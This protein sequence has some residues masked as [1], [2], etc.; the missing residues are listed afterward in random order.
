VL[1]ALVGATVYE[2]LVAL[3]AIELGYVPGDGPPGEGLV[4]SIALVAML[5]GGGLVAF[6]PPAPFGALVAPAAA[7]F[8][9]ARFYTFDPYYLP[10]LRR[11]SDGGLVSPALVFAVAALALCAAAITLARPRAGRFMAPPVILACAFLALVV[12]GGH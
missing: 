2:T 4:L 6:R 8:L 7:A 10:T 3:G 11:M 1:C 9:V 5:A 12:D